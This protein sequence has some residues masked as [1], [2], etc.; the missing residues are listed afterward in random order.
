MDSLCKHK[1]EKKKRKPKL[2]RFQVA[3][4]ICWCDTSIE[5]NGD[6][7]HLCILFDSDLH[8][9]WYKGVPEDLRIQIQNEIDDF[10]NW[11]GEE[12]EI[13]ASGQTCTLGYR[14]RDGDPIPE[15]E[16]AKN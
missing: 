7:K 8:A 14:L 6:Y 1:R 11:R 5:V 15:D 12:Y 9:Y 16:Y 13:S 2:V 10:R 4:G 3:T